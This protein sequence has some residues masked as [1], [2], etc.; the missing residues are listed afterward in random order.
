MT[1][2]NHHRYHNISSFLLRSMIPF[3]PCFAWSTMIIWFRVW[4][5]ETY[6]HYYSYR[7][8]RGQM[9]QNRAK[10]SIHAGKSSWL[11]RAVLA[12]PSPAQERASHAC[13]GKGNPCLRPVKARP[14]LASP[15]P[16]IPRLRP[17]IVALLWGCRT[18]RA[19]N[20]AQW[21]L[22]EGEREKGRR[23]KKVKRRERRKNKKFRKNIYIL[24][25]IV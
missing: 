15:G 22:A 13:P 2:E 11:V 25:K 7:R 4:Y 20:E 21:W 10:G 1:I 12:L 9:H 18:P 14:I 16:G 5:T 23:K 24:L 3:S 17:T 19:I 8:K 6:F